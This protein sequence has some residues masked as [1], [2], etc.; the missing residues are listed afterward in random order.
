MDTQFEQS[1]HN[2]EAKHF[3]FRSRRELVCNILNKNSKSISILDVGCSTGILLE[4]LHKN[5]F[6]Q[7]QLFGI[8]ISEKAVSQANSRGLKNVSVGDAQDFR[9]EHSFDVIIAS[10]CLEHLSNDVKAIETWLSH[11]KPEGKL[12]IFVPAF[13]SLWSDHDVVN[14]HK[15]R[16]TKRELIS[17]FRYKNVTILKSGY[18]NVFLF[19]LIWLY[20]QFN[21]VSSSETKKAKGDL[22]SLSV[23]NPIMYRILKAEQ[24]LFGKISFPFGVST[25]CIVE[26]NNA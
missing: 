3:W 11:L 4:D 16:Y 10:D 20:R 7:N 15:R 18:W 1:Y 14:N 17:L 2:L 24:P 13:M 8:D 21:K 22:E 25:Y 23:F 9:F 6:D 19:P 5:G 26:K 12:I